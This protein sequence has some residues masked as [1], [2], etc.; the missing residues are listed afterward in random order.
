MPVPETPMHE[1]CGAESRQHYVGLTG[2]RP[3]VEPKAETGSEQFQA[4]A[5][6]AAEPERTRLYDQMAAMMP[7]AMKTNKAV[8]V[9]IL[10]SPSATAAEIAAGRVEP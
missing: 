6:V 8:A 3:H 9:T 2:E 7:G 1:D 10:L 5:T 4:R